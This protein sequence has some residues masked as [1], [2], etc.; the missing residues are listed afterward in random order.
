VNAQELF[1]DVSSG[2]FLDGE[3]TIPTNKPT[4]YSDEVRSTKINLRKVNN[5][6]LS[7]VTGSLG[8]SLKVRLGTSTA[9]LADGTIPGAS[10]LPLIKATATI[11]TLGSAQASAIGSVATFT[12]VTAT[13]TAGI[14]TNSV[15]SK[16]PEFGTF[17]T[18]A[19]TRLA[20][21]SANI[22]VVTAVTATAKTLINLPALVTPVISASIL[23]SI[24]PTATFA[25][26]GSFG[27]ILSTG[28]D[29]AIVPINPIK[30]SA[31]LNTPIAATF[32]STMTGGSV[33]TISISGI[34]NGYPNGTYPLTF[35]GASTTSA[36]ANATALG[37][38]I[39]SVNIVDSGSG[40][41]FAP[42]VTLFTPDKSLLY[43]LPTNYIGKIDGKDSF[44]WIAPTTT[45]ARADLLFTVPTSSSIVTG[46]SVPS[47][48]ISFYA[49]SVSG[50]PTWQITIVCGGYGYIGSPSITRES[51]LVNAENVTRKVNTAS[52]GLIVPVSLAPNASRLTSAGGGS[53]LKSIP[54]NETISKTPVSLEDGGIYF[55]IKQESKVNQNWKNIDVKVGTGGDRIGP[56]IFYT[57]ATQPV[58]VY[59]SN[60]REQLTPK[61][62]IY[63]GR[64][65]IYV[66]V[67][68]NNDDRITS[69]RQIGATRYALLKISASP[70]NTSYN[71][72]S[73]DLES[74]SPP[75]SVR[76]QIGVRNA[77]V[78]VGIATNPFYS[79][80]PLPIWAE[81]I[82]AG[83]SL[84]GYTGLKIANQIAGNQ[85]YGGGIYEPKIEIIDFGSGYTQSAINSGFKLVELGS[86]TADY[87][88]L[89]D[90]RTRE[91]SVLT[92]G[93][94]PT[95]I[96]REM[97]VATRP[98]NGVIQ[99]YIG[100][101]GVGYIGNAFVTVGQTS[102]VTSV[103]S[104]SFLTQPKG[105]SPGEYILTTQ[106]PPSG[107]T[108]T[109]AMVI[110][111][112][113]AGNPYVYVQSPG[114][115]YT[116]IP[117]ITAPDPNILSGNVNFA[118][119]TNTPQGYSL[120]NKHYFSVQSSP[121]QGGN[122]IIYMQNSQAYIE[123]QG[124]GYTTAPIVTA[125]AP[126][127]SIT[128][129]GYISS[130]RVATRGL[131]YG[132]E[133]FPLDIAPSP[134]SGGNAQ[135]SF[136]FEGDN[137][138]IDL[139]N[140]GFGY[141]TAPVITAP[142]PNPSASCLGVVNVYIKSPG[143]GYYNGVPYFLQFTPPPAGGVAPIAR[144]LSFAGEVIRVNLDSGGYG[145]V[146]APAVQAPL[147]D[148]KQSAEDKGFIS[149]INLTNNPVGYQNGTYDLTVGPSPASGG[150]AIISLNVQDE[151]YGF[152]IQNKGYG[153][154]T[155]PII[156][157]PAPNALQGQLA[158]ISITTIGRGYAP[159][160]YDCVVDS[161]PTGGQTAQVR[162]DSFSRDSGEF[163]ILDQGHGYT[164]AVSISVPT[165]QGS[166][167][168]SITIVCGGSFYT[169]DTS[170][171]SISDASGTGYSL[172]EIVL[173]A[174]AVQ[175]IQVIDG[176]R[177]FGNSPKINFST[178]TRP[179]LPSYPPDVIAADFNITTASAN[180][181][182]STSTQRDILMEVFETD[183]T[184]EQVISQ[185]TVS[186]AKRVLE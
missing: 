114:S 135:A 28:I 1:L 6:K 159:G 177:G 72:I 90:S 110:P 14:S 153:Y 84:A 119:V 169:R 127:I 73:L 143:S 51:V 4:F 142:A 21:F 138:L 158:S 56:V 41:S 91:I 61:H 120:N 163:I 31:V 118:Y 185:A 108:A 95:L 42:T 25:M 149:N 70:I 18:S 57:T 15:A 39:V 128:C 36:I 121:S 176:G 99:Y 86:L 130:I 46:L 38:K 33:T 132:S 5:N 8:S 69:G 180:T 44:N 87:A 76:P 105:Y 12:A 29:L 97:G 101:G 184:S 35:V 156:V 20:Q 47:A 2:R 122:A 173:S 43:V 30:F 49:P 107:T 182:L 83:V 109:V 63:A 125:P 129:S 151:S 165:P 92:R 186:L 131:G 166:I 136:Y 171:F 74:N 137:C 133:V 3:S 52:A 62:N 98:S 117:T 53:G 161:A 179:V 9:K 85:S 58:L 27:D 134:V 34:G 68:P 168:S 22:Q 147:P 162:F 148:F 37:G 164:S 106:Q 48:F 67:V 26:Q 17:L 40:Y 160:S 80:E 59:G 50:N 145:Y 123:S 124:F 172:G 96:S 100:D 157:A 174:G 175:S 16:T 45:T 178:P 152:A 183:G 88:F 24:V 113:N 54:L 146:T 11:V 103:V 75:P 102:G 141:T 167:I 7:S 115:G 155:A 144:F 13:I 89:S 66:A 71:V 79:F 32:T 139:Y 116:S 111:P 77:S 65:D 60:S 55:T 94:I 140:P 93:F 10:T 170:S 82:P 81:N 154:V 181:I 64:N 19:T 126:D 150:N 23:G 104:V 78:P 112:A